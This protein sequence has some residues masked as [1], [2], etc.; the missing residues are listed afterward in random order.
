MKKI[1]SC[2]LIC[3]FSHILY[4]EAKSEYIKDSTIQETISKLEELY[5][6]NNRIERG[7][8]HTASLWIKEDGTAA[9]FTKFAIKYYVNDN[10]SLYNLI[11]DLSRRFQL[12]DGHSF[13]INRIFSIPINVDTGE[14]TPLEELFGNYSIAANTNKGYYNSKIAFLIS[15]NYPYYTDEEKEKYGESWSSTE[16]GYALL[17]DRFKERNLDKQKIEEKEEKIENGTKKKKNNEIMKIVPGDSQLYANNTTISLSSICSP[18]GKELFNDNIQLLFHWKMRDEI[19]MLYDLNDPQ[20]L[21]KQRAIYKAMSRFIDQTIPKQLIQG[22]GYKWNPYTNELRKEGIIVKNESTNNLRYAYIRNLFI[23]KYEH[24]HDSTKYFNN[25]FK[26]YGVSAEQVENMYVKILSSPQAKQIA[27]II[28]NKL[29]R[30]LEPFDVWYTGFNY[31]SN[32]ETSKLDTKIKALYPTPLSLEKAIPSILQKLGF[33]PE[34]SDYYGSKIQ[35]DPARANGHSEGA[36]MP[37]EKAHIRTNFRKDGLD[38]GGYQT[39]MHELGHSVQQTIATYNINIDSQ[40][41]LPNSG[42]VESAAVLFEFRT[43]K[44]LLKS[45]DCNVDNMLVLDNFW[46]TYEI[47]GPALW[48]LKMWQWMYHI[49]EFTVEELKDKSIAIAKDIWNEYYAPIIGTKNHIMQAV[50]N[51]TLNASLY[52]SSY[53]LAHMIHIQI[54]DYIVDKDFC[55]E[56][57]RIFGQG[58]MA[59][60]VWMK[61]AVGTNLSAEPILNYTDKALKKYKK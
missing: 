43:W 9:E 49:K 1:L 10:D 38:F 59:P 27:Q 40:R 11:L 39:A 33:T 58:N 15:L 36:N 37:G 52:L 32:F 7:V 22:I 57:E 51:H 60:N 29:S 2:L 61:R 55:T 21:E 24:Q 8:R 45:S 18:G 34:K 46:A 35:V 20:K 25:Y 54:E 30:D 31:R 5:G 17:G 53:A 26:D 41:L 6:K 56:V 47:V 4:G 48:E 44:S 12:I 13:K 50:Y 42:I 3:L 23:S 14:I 16:W 28:R 19:K